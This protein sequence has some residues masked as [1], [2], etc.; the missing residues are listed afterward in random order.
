MTQ[1][2]ESTGLLNVEWHFF[3]DVNVPKHMIHVRN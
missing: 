2:S 3:I 1:V